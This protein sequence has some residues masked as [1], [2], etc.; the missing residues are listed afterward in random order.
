MPEFTI[1]ELSIPT[2]VN[3]TGWADFEHTID[4][5]NTVEAITYGTTDLSFTA[6]EELPY[7]RNTFQPRRVLVARVGG[8]IVGRATYETQTGESADTGW[9]SVEVLADYRGRGIG[10]ALAEQ[11]ESLVAADGKVKLIAYV[12]IQDVD[13]PRLTSPTGFGSVPLEN[14][15]VKFL[16]AREYSFEQVERMS[17]LPLPMSGLRE[18]VSAA[19]A[20]SGPEYRMVLWNGR[21]P[22]KWRGDV[23]T[24]GTRMSTD[25][26]SAGLEEPEDVWTVERV[27][28]GDERAEASG[29]DRVVAAVEHVATGALVGFTMLAVPPSPTRAVSQY[30]TLV[31]REH[32]GHRLGML[33]KV[34]NL[35]HLERLHPGRPSVTTFNAE[36]NRYMLDVNEAVGFVPIGYEAAWRKDL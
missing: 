16:L 22:E 19:T 4:V 26:P 28:E 35:E 15:D 12:G 11:I 21:T 9:V 18:L 1:D 6:V 5:G 8:E 20:S 17:R 23:A 10:R 32:R 29:L 2:A 30:A 24:L 31:L 13:G 3:G 25:A 7:Y 33:L 14:R 27:L 36:E 34:A